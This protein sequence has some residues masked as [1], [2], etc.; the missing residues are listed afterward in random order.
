MAGRLTKVLLAALLLAGA[1]ANVA[2]VGGADTLQPQ[3]F[4]MAGT[5]TSVTPGV[6]GDVIGR[7]V[8]DNTY[9]RGGDISAKSD[10]VEITVKQ[11]TRFFEDFDGDGSYTRSDLTGTVKPE[12]GFDV[13]VSGRFDLKN[14]QYTFLANNVFSPPPPISSGGPTAV[15]PAPN[16]PRDMTSLRLFWIRGIVRFTGTRLIPSCCSSELYGFEVSPVEQ[17]SSWH[18]SAIAAAHGN[19]LRIYEQPGTRYWGSGKMIT[20]RDLVVQTGNIVEVSGR[21][22]WDGLDWRMVAT[23]VVR[24]PEG[25]TQPAGGTLG[26]VATLARTGDGTFNESTQSWEGTTFEGRG[27]NFDGQGNGAAVGLTLD[28]T[29]NDVNGEW[30]YA[31]TYFVQKD[32]SPNRLE[33][34]ITGTVATAN[35]G[36]VTGVMTVDQAYGPWAGWGGFGRILRGA[37]GYLGP[38]SSASPPNGFQAELWW[39]IS[40]SP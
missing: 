5:D 6:V 38:P 25:P 7:F 31:G 18:V 8:L 22:F 20:E 4:E 24:V 2:G 34:Q 26:T 28:W 14:G 13:W 19:G 36:P 33:G 32:N 1:L 11:D 23:Q 15:N 12:D 35:P 27:L 9:R 3:P 10:P 29:Y 30:D 16:L 17:T 39:Q 37:A 40:E 21:Y